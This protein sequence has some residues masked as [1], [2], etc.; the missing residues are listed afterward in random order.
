M[1]DRA[2]TQQACKKVWEYNSKMKRGRGDREGGDGVGGWG[3]RYIEVEFFFPENTEK[4]AQTQM[5]TQIGQQLVNSM[6]LVKV[7]LKYSHCSFSYI[8]ALV[9]P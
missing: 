5:G 7:S 9:P 3:E 8:I 1:P 2:R 4:S 6:H